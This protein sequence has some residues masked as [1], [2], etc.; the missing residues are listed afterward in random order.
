LELRISNGKDKNQTRS[1]K[2]TQAVARRTPA[3]RH[4][5]CPQE[6]IRIC[7][8]EKRRTQEK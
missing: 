5:I 6:E 1:I 8:E 2:Q 7:P 4:S 3:V